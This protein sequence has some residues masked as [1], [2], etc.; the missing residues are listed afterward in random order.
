MFGG[1]DVGQH[2]LQDVGGISHQGQINGDVLAHLTGVNVNLDALGVVG[3]GFR[4]Q[5]HTVGEPG[6]HGNQQVG[7]VH[8]LVG[9]VAAVHAQQPQVQRLTVGQH[10]GCHQGVGGG[11][12]GLGQQVP[13]RLTARS[14]TDTAAEHHHRLFGGIDHLGGLLDAFLVKVGDGA[15][16][17]RRLGGELAG[18]C[19]HILGNVHQHRPLAAALGNAEGG[20][21]GVG[22]ILHPADGV[23]VLGDGHGHALDVGFLKAVLAQQG[24]GHVAGKGNHRHAVHERGGNAGDQVGGTG[25]A[26]GQHHAGAAGGTGITVGS[27]GGALLMGGQ[28]VPDPVGI[29]IQLVVQV[30]NRAAG[31]AKNGIHALL[32]QHLDKNLGTCQHHRDPLLFLLYACYEKSPALPDA[33]KTAGYGKMPK[34]KQPLSP[35][36]TLALSRDK[37][38]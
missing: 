29:F 16:R 14:A 37:G 22:Q 2:R 8:R 3:E 15:H 25:T 20:T 31:I 34:R 7:F 18:V 32:G 10:T 13:Q 21:H 27:V 38:R 36:R 33:G 28:D 19:G 24:G 11:D 23:V 9:G 4:L 26:G 6:T 5:R 17:L 30:Q 12:L 1:L 35:L